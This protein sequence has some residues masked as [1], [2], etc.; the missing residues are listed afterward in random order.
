M[1]LRLTANV[2]TMARIILLPLPCALLI[3]D[4]GPSKWVAFVLFALLGATDFVDG[5]M[6]RR[7]GPTKLG[8]LIDPV[9]DKI[10][11]ASACFGLA[12][13]G[14]LPVWVLM[15]IMSREF[16]ITALRTSVGF[17][18]ESIKTSYLAK[19]KTIIQMGGFGTI[20]LTMALNRYYA[21]GTAV[22]LCLGLLVF[23]GLY[24]FKKRKHP[25]YWVLPVAGAFLYWTILSIY[26][27]PVSSV[28]A[29]LLVIV[30]ITWI[31]CIDYIFGTYKMF[32][33]T[34]V[35]VRDLVRICWA[36][37]HTLLAAPLIEYYPNLILPLLVSISFELALGGVDMI[38]ASEQKYAGVWPFIIT[39]LAA[40]LTFALIKTTSLDPMFV[41]SALAVVSISVFIV[42]YYKWSF[43]FKRSLGIG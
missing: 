14:V 1:Q 12:V 8:G 32:L 22:A 29:Q 37:A 33:R 38:V 5:A 19:M 26:F 2:V 20:F 43:L 27:E 41:G 42:V 25:P 24:W 16:F 21:I 30:A 9:A 4:T 31:S 3:W 17:R 6:A 15:A 11:I 13:V 40:T 10:F 39:P 35:G 23:Y 28:F 18:E 34:G 7:E 36:L